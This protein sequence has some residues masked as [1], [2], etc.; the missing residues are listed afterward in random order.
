MATPGETAMPANTASGR[1]R[2]GATRL[3]R[4]CCGGGGL[5]L[6]IEAGLDKCRQR[7]KRLLGVPA[8][9]A[10]LDLCAWAGAEHHQAHDR[11]RRDRL[12]VADYVHRGAK[13]LGHHDELGRGSRMQPAFVGDGDDAAQDRRA[14]RRWCRFRR[15]VAARRR[16]HPQEPLPLGLHDG[17]TCEAEA[18]YFRPASSA[19]CTAAPSG[20]LDRTLASFTSIG[21]LTPAIT[22]TPF[23]AIIEIARLDGVPPNMSVSSTTPSPVSH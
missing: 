15:C 3:R 11:P 12:A 4:L 5:A 21:R 19:Q 10:Q 18:I 8:L 6:F 2:S 22:S 14:G 23:L 20:W 9:G 16:C 1:E 17:N 13:A 7:V